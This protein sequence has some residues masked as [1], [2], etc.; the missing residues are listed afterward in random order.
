MAQATGDPYHDAPQQPDKGMRV[1]YIADLLADGRYRTRLTVRAL[2]TRWDVTEHT[3]SVDAAEA[4]RLLLVPKAERE[5]MRAR[6]V[7]QLEALQADAM[8]RYSKVTGLPDY[9]AVVK[10]VELAGRWMGL[11]EELAD[12]K[13]ANEVKVEILT[14]GIKVAKPEPSES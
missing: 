3:L 13:R 5:A 8:T 11:D 10:A 4:H 9:G 12:N 2:A 7:Q 14:T 6:M 1:A